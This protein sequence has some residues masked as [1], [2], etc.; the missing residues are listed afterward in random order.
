MSTTPAP[1]G[2]LSPSLLWTTIGS[3]VLIFLGAFESLAVTTIMPIVSEELDGRA[4]YAL[5]FS[6]TLAASIVGTVAGGFWAD[7]RGPA[8]PLLGGILVFIVGLV[9]SGAAITMEMF[10]VG[11]FFQGLGSGAINVALYVVVARLYPAALHPRIFGLFATVWLIP[12]LIGPPVAGFIAEVFSWHW[13][14]LGVGVLVLVAAG[15]IIPSLLTL[16]RMPEHGADATSSR[17][18][19]PLSLAAALGV[20]GVS[21]AGE[22]GPWAWPVALVALVVA[23]AALRPLFPAGTLLAKPGMPAAIALRGVVASAFFAIEAFQPLLFVERF[24]YPPWLAGL[25]LTVGGVAWAVSSEVQGRLGERIDHEATLRLGTVLAVIGLVWQLA[26]TL[27]WLAPPVAA[28]GW[29]IAGVGMG[30][31]YPRVSTLVLAHSGPGEQG[32]NT[33]AMSI[34]DLSGA[35]SSIAIAGLLFAAF[36]GVDGDGFAAVFIMGAVLVLVTLPIAWRVKAPVS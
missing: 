15:S 13:V 25:I 34:A 23:F 21:L 22:L 31:I 30:L 9:L 5:A 2:L 3:A 16:L 26:T 1:K 6:A 12:S 33:G 8:G 28:V 27:L 29:L 24:E 20:L 17:W 35:A 32:F 14:F 7:R 19:V 18:I 11:R 10:V 36:G 4:L